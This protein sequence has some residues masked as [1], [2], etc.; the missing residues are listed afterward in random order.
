MTNK[1]HDA[2]KFAVLA[3]DTAVFTINEEELLV[4]LISVDRPPH[5]KNTR[6]L[7][8]GLLLPHENAEEAALRHVATKALIAPEKLYLEQLYTFSDVDRDP[9]GRVVAVVY[10]AYVPFESLTE[11]ERANGIDTWWESVASARKLAYD[12]DEVLT[13]AVARLR[14][15]A[16]YTSLLSQLM[17]K[18][19][20]LTEL[21]AAFEC[22]LGTAIDKRNFRKKIAK[23][24]VLTETKRMKTGGRFRPARLYRFASKGV[25]EIEVL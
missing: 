14:T 18:E 22:V 24:G 5:F 13:L 23:L 21:E 2:L 17:P 9:R 1:Q 11:A 8:G 6:G 16:R 4:R 7:P 20:T 12:H 3:A 19:F 25:K 10:A 15:R